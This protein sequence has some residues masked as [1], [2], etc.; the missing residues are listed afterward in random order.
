MAKASEITSGNDAWNWDKNILGQFFLRRLWNRALGN[1]AIFAFHLACASQHDQTYRL[2]EEKP[3][4]H[5]FLRKSLGDSYLLLFF[6][7]DGL[8]DFMD[9]CRDLMETGASNARLS[10]SSA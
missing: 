6:S 9:E 5:T 2:S 8:N 4:S 10:S 3:L 1:S 7:V